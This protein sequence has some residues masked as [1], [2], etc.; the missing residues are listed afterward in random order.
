VTIN[1]VCAGNL[2]LTV[3]VTLLGGTPGATS[4]INGAGYV[5]PAISQTGAGTTVNLQ[6]LLVT[7]GGH[8]SGDGGGVW[9]DAGCG[10]VTNV[11]ASRVVGN[12][13]DGGTD[14]WGAG[15]NAENC[16]TMNVTNS[17]I[18]ANKDAEAEGNGGGIAL[19]CAKAVNLTGTSVG[20]NVSGGYGGGVYVRTCGSTTF[21]AVAS[22]ISDNTAANNGGGIYSNGSVSL[23][24]STLTANTA[25]NGGGIYFAGGGSAALSLSDVSV[26]HNT[27]STGDGGGIANESFSGNAP[28]TIDG[29][30]VSFNRA[31]A[32]DGGGIA[33]YGVNGHTASAL[34]T[35]S[36]M[37]GN[38]AR[39]G[40]GGAIANGTGAAGGTATM[41]LG[42]T[43]IGSAVPPYLNPNQA[44]LG[45]GIYNDG[46]H[47]PASVSLQAQTNVVH[48]TASVDGGGIYN[49]NGASL[50]IAPGVI[51]L[52]NSPDNIS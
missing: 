4:G 52:F 39:N 19:D 34:I 11:L 1:G 8:D 43:D 23:Q 26:D 12:T 44:K 29:S 37:V 28:L 7:G 14:A 5:G 2:N 47:G 36:V 15:L 40:E 51:I 45:G 3:N 30:A 9:N 33:N 46:S 13:I 18:F 22:T 42:S 49:T 25:I 35:N 31:S 24:N 10:A 6:N 38:L 20:P 17:T 32:G 21:S 27:A 48:N 16:T 41:S 50:L